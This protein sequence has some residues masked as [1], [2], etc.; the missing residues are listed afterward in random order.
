MPRYEIAY[1]VVSGIDNSTV[2]EGTTRLR[3]DD[4][5]AATAAAADWAHD[6]DPRADA[7]IDPRIAV[8]GIEELPELWLEDE[9]V[10][11]GPD[12]GPYDDDDAAT[13]AIE[14]RGRPATFGI[15]A[16]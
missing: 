13:A 5:D 4:E 8:D 1:R 9:A 12:H 14:S 3:A 6:N 7:R 16:R 10:P 15:V 2:S 11:A